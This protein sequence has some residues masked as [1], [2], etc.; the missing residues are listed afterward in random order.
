MV[1]FPCSRELDFDKLS[2]LELLL[3]PHPYR[4]KLIHDTEPC[5]TL[6]RED[7]LVQT[8]QDV[9]YARLR[10]VGV[11]MQC[12]PTDPLGK[13][14][15]TYKTTL[16][17]RFLNCETLTTLTFTVGF[18][19]SLTYAS[20]LTF[21]LGVKSVGVTA[22]PAINKLFTSS[23]LPIVKPLRHEAFTRALDHWQ[24]AYVTSCKVSKE[25]RAE[26]NELN[27]FALHQLGALTLIKWNNFNNLKQFNNLNQFKSAERF[28]LGFEF[29]DVKFQPRRNLVTG[30][31]KSTGNEVDLVARIFQPF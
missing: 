19:L 15:K 4:N 5:H 25:L 3:L 12:L 27:I 2:S 6:R 26:F 28:N 23:F 7:I 14:K 29:S 8:R 13:K 17:K 21:C 24:N 9:C 11:N 10:T 31:G 30:K 20:K 1:I 18:V 16:W 22:A